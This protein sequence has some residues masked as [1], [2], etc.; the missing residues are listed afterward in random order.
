LESGTRVSL[1]S[2]ADFLYRA[3]SGGTGNLNGSDGSDGE[4][5]QLD[6]VAPDIVVAESEP[7]GSAA[8]AQELL[9]AP[10][11][12]SGFVNSG[13]DA[14]EANPVF[15][16]FIQPGPPPDRQEDLY[17]IEV[18]ENGLAV[19]RL[20]IQNSS[21]DI[22]IYLLDGV[23]GN[24]VAQSNDPAGAS[25]SFQVGVSP[26]TYF[27][28][29]SWCCD[30]PGSNYTLGFGP[31]DPVPVVPPSGLS[32]VDV[33]SAG[34]AL[35]TLDE[36]SQLLWLDVTAN[37]GRSFDAVAA[38]AGGWTAL[39]FRPAT[40]GEV[41]GLLGRYALVPRPCPGAFGSAVSADLVTRVQQLLGITALTAT[42]STLRATFESGGAS[43]GL[44][45][46]RF[47]GGSSTASVS[48]GVQSRTAADP[49]LGHFLVRP[50]PE[51]SAW[52][53]AAGALGTLVVIRR[54]SRRPA[55]PSVVAF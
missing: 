54:R 22:D 39:G 20:D 46:L 41:C 16:N 13:D 36:E 53:L 43:A 15:V 52:A 1:A 26:G 49:R 5:G 45:S 18:I 32:E 34:D 50:A 19:V 48:A 27:L 38:G 40:S 2:E 42:S 10:L 9:L 24:V 25:E 17:E 30:T 7:N 6:L 55:S 33:F 29:V 14:A 12:L 23:T 8:R 21:T 4:A 44:V 47:S 31:L 28:G 35:A 37:V 51:P 11:E 3:G